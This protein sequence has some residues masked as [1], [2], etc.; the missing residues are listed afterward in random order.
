MKIAT[1]I[2]AALLVLLLTSWRLGDVSPSTDA[3]RPPRF[4]ACT[5]ADDCQVC[6]N[7][8]YCK[9]C[10]KQGGTCG[11]CAWRKGKR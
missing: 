8:R 6:K 2:L 7:C 9:H 3:R 10:A 1:P 4:A 11:V 5:G